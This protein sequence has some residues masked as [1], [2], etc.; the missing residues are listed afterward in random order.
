[1]SHECP[2]CGAELV[3]EDSFG[4][5]NMAAQ[6]KYGYGWQKLGNIYRCPNHEGFNDLW[7]TETYIHNTC[8]GIT[9]EDYLIDLGLSCWEEVVCDSAYHHVSGSFYDYGDGCLHEGYP[10]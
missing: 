4:K 10:C 5:G 1:M 8:N 6:E 3:W 2:Y 9:V 7:A